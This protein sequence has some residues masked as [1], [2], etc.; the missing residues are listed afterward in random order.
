[1]LSRPIALS[2][3][4]SLLVPAVALAKDNNN[5]GFVLSEIQAGSVVTVEGDE[6]HYRNG[7]VW[8]DPVADVAADA[9]AADNISKILYLNR[10][11]GGCVIQPGNNDARNNTS[12]IAGNNT[13]VISEYQWPQDKWDEMVACVR[14]VYSPYDV[15]VVTEDPG[16]EFHHEA[17][18]AGLA[19]DLGLDPLIGGIAP[20]GCAPLN[21]VISFSF[22][23]SPAYPNGD[24]LKICWTVAQES[25]HS[26]G[27][28]NHVFHC[29]DPMTYLDGG[30]GKKFFRNNNFPCGEFQLAD[31]NCS[32]LT[33]NSHVEL[34]GVFGV[35]TMP[36]APE[37]AILLP[38]QDDVVTDEFSIYWDALDER[39]IL[40]TELWINGSKYQEI[41]GHDFEHQNDNYNISAPPLPDGI[42][43][44]EMRA[45][46]QIGSESIQKITV[47]KGDACTSKESCFDF[48][49]CNAGRCEYGP[50][51]A[52]LGDSCNV[53]PNCLEGACAEVD[54]ERVCATECTLNVTGACSEG[55]EC[56]MSSNGGVCWPAGET[57][58][59]CSVA[60]SKHDP[61]PWFG[62]GMFL[63]GLMLLRRR[64]A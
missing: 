38:K 53:D 27:L 41:P 13:A 29:S 30:C 51:A 25:A 26:Y 46:N 5:K 42:I 14:D 50:A 39:L 40:R 61:L 62:L 55:F 18:V 36:P 22:A 33:Q 7:W 44:V 21:N 57:G 12:T 20:A 8:V 1:M 35:G 63:V 16:D 52:E 2:I 17:I 54:G 10:C 60:G 45:Y 48:Q 49:E 6:P 47:T 3:A 23:N 34:K 56:V 28:P 9:A 4:V 11:A 15:Q 43:D 32:G 31:C 58:G 19:G 24:P 64:R 59:C 37:L